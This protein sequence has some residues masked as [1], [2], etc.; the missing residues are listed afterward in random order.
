MIELVIDAAGKVWSAE[1]VGDADK[2]LAYAAR[3]WKF[4]PA[5]VNGRAVAS[6]L[7]M[8]VSPDL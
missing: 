6:R 3:G 8:V 1:P 7:R 4:I 5:F 2:D